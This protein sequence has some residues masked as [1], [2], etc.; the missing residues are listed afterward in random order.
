M[1]ES[2]CFLFQG[3]INVGIPF[4]SR[5]WRKE[6][7]LTGKG[8]KGFSVQ[9]LL[10]DRAL[11]WSWF[12]PG[13]IL[14]WSWFDPGLI[15]VWSWFDPGLILV[16]FWFDSGL[17][18]VWSWFDPGLILVWFWFHL[19][20]ILVS[21]WFDFDLILIW[22]WFDLVWAACALTTELLITRQTLNPFTHSPC[23]IIPAETRAHFTHPSHGRFSL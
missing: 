20:F 18:L 3:A 5:T 4:G 23:N 11:V 17:I 13:L 15:L 14:V 1:N 8:L 12:D 7:L 2:C 19:G 21:S 9:W 10:H 22:S 16:W 6:A